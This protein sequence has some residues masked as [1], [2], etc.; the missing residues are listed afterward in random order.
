[1]DELFWHWTH[2]LVFTAG[3]KH[4]A[5]TAGAYWLID[6]VA[7]Y[8]ADRR[9]QG[10]EFQTWTLK[11][12]P[13]KSATLTMTDGNDGPPRITQHIEFTDYADS[14]ESECELYVV[15]PAPLTLMLPCEY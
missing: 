11:V 3:V 12:N 13:D 10:E 7:S 9:V 1:M 6:A 4:I 8:Q 15:G 2:R 14:G 5:D